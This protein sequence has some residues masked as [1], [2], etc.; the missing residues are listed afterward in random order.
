MKDP[1]RV[2]EEESSNLPLSGYR[3]LNFTDERGAYCSKI[4]ADLGADVI[5]IEPPQGD[6]ARKVGPF[7]HDNPRPDRSLYWFAYYTNQRSITLNIE[8]SDGQRIFKKLVE[9]SAFV[10]ESFAP[11]YMDRLGLG[12]STLRQINPSLVMTSITPFGQ[13]GPYKDWKASDIVL[14]AMGMSM[15]LMGDPD[16]PPLRIGGVEQSHL[17]AGIY[18]AA[19][20]MIA[21][22]YRMVSGQGQHVDVSSQESVLLTT[23]GLYLFQELE[24]YS[25]KR[26][27]NYVPRWGKEERQIWP[28]RDGYIM[29]VPFLGAQGRRTRNMVEW[30]DS[31]G[32]AGDL[33]N[34]HWEEI[35]YEEVGR[36]EYEHWQSLFAEFIKKHT[37]ADFEREALA[38]DLSV[39]PASTPKELLANSQLAAR[40]YWV[41]VEYPELNCTITHPGAAYKSSGV[42]WG[43]PLL[44]PLLGEH[45]RE[46]YQGELGLS[47]E[48]MGLLKQDNVI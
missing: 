18:A 15:S 16:R 9:N 1:R 28:C 36:E 29:F 37:K 10:L 46:I 4:L 24:G 14:S 11:G 23:L 42:A 17:V 35:G 38:R 25:L 44:A 48:E 19:G 30:M 45:N 13:D 41:E 6:P 27:G 2:S 20:T 7:F 3:V 43:K 39:L 32:L 47:E 40:N 33:K 31:E 8:T 22:Y 5:K 21:H 34:V 12:Y 26:T